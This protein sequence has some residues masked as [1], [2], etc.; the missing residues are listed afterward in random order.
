MTGITL[1]SE[2][3]PASLA[4]FV[5]RLIL[6]TATQTLHQVP[7]LNATG[8]QLIGVH[9]KPLYESILCRLAPRNNNPTEPR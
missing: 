6:P 7:P 5:S 3:S 2:S 8:L 4:I 9:Y 1:N